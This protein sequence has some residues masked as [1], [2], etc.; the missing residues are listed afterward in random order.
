[1]HGEVEVE[2][3]A[4]WE[5]SMDILIAEDEIDIVFMYT[6]LLE[7][8]GHNVTVT[9]DGQECLDLYHD[10]SRTMTRR[11]DVN[12]DTRIPFDAVI[13]DHK[14]PMMDGFQVANEIISINPRQRIII[15]SGYDKD[16]FEEAAE[17][18]QLPIEVLQKPFS[19]INLVNL[20]EGNSKKV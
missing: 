16:I 12:G 13:L 17:H 19:R 18:F 5:D 1:M 20:L 8:R 14:M 11:A 9:Y 4:G 6:N 3:G 7:E 2:Y 10:K 15:A